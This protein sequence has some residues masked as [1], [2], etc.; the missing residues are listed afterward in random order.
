MAAQA[1]SYLGRAA[2]HCDY[3]RQGDDINRDAKK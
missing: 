2:G 3:G 1:A